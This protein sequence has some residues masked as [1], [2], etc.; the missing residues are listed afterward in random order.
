MGIIHLGPG[1]TMSEMQTD[2]RALYEAMAKHLTDALIHLEYANR[3]K[4]M[5]ALAKGKRLI[6]AQNEKALIA[7]SMAVVVEHDDDESPMDPWHDFARNGITP[8]PDEGAL[9][10]RARELGKEH[11]RQISAELRGFGETASEAEGNQ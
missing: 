4:A 2:Y 3:E 11:S 8:D 6:D 9:Y 5:L 7:S 1:Q 10:Q